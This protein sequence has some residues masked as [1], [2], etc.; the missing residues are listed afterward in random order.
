LRK[1][2]VRVL[3]RMLGDGRYPVAPDPVAEP[4]EEVKQGGPY[5]REI[6]EFEAENSKLRGKIVELTAALKSK[7]GE[8]R[9][10]REHMQMLSEC[11]AE[12]NSIIG[13][14]E[15][16]VASKNVGNAGKLAARNIMSG[17]LEQTPQDSQQGKSK[18]YSATL[19][20]VAQSQKRTLSIKNCHQV[21]LAV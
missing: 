13:K 12:Q 4:A 8:L 16:V 18:R 5:D 15:K 14:I 7:D 21:R 10:M 6:A 11:T 19:L 17:Q 3:G 9:Q 20:I 1:K 2:E